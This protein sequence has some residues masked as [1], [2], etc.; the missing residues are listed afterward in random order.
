MK[1]T[2]KSY[3]VWMMDLMM[4]EESRIIEL[5]EY[6]IDTTN[7]FIRLAIRIVIAFV[8]LVDLSEPL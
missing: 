3:K 2:S 8:F 6:C 7:Q 4:T 5:L 1:N